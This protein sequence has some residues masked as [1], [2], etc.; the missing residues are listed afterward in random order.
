MKR[1]KKGKK[2]GNKYK[3]MSEYL[4]FD[5]AHLK[6]KAHVFPVTDMAAILPHCSQTL[7][8]DG[9]EEPRA[10]QLRLH[11]TQGLPLAVW[12]EHPVRY[13]SCVAARSDDSVHRN[14]FQNRVRSVE[15]RCQIP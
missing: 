15:K 14:R 10:E 2:N 8:V 11:S 12:V 3:V 13:Y 9:R 1:G 6:L 5:S 4:I 7:P